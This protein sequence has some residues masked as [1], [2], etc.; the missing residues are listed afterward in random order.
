MAEG[1]APAVASAY[2]ADASAARDRQCED[3]EVEADEGY[4]VSHKE[5]R[6]ICR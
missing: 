4:G 6:R 5:I 1:G 2:Q 3:Q